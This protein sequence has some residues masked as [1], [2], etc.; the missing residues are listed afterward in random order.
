MPIYIYVSYISY[1]YMY[2]PVAVE[3]IRNVPISKA[4]PLIIRKGGT[5]LQFC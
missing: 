4:I 1:K 2:F 5:P 3:L